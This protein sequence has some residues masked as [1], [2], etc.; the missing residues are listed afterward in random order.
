MQI[1][2]ENLAYLRSLKR[3]KNEDDVRYKE[4][5]KR[6]LLDDE[7]IL[8]LLHN[9]KFEEEDA[10]ADDYFGTNILDHYIVYPSQH[11]VKNFICFE[12]SMD[13]V[14]RYNS[15]IKY[16]QVIFYVICHEEDINVAEVGAARHDL[17]AAV[18]TDMFQGSNCLGFQLK[19]VSDK[20]SVLDNKYPARTLIFEQ[21]TTNS[22]TDK[23]GQHVGLRYGKGHN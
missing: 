13:E 11:N 3:E 19:L 6:K 23:N 9:E 15:I 18:L 2:D 7:C 16:Q 8:Y 10:E 14:S 4:I 21:Y 20:P 22:V 12:T 1:S 17:L 5:I